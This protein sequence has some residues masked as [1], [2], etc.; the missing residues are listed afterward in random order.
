[1]V[2]V[3]TGTTEE[4]QAQTQLEQMGAAR[5]A[6]AAEDATATATREALASTCVPN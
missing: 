2:E 3:E 1:V 5:R 6:S 4:M